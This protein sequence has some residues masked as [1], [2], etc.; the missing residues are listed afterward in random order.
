MIELTMMSRAG[1]VEFMGKK[2]KPYR[3]LVG[4][5]EGRNEQMSVCVVIII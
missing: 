2:M 3:V 1:H 5:L 4:K